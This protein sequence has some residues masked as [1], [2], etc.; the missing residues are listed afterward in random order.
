MT[1]ELRSDWKYLAPPYLDPYT[2]MDAESQSRN[3]PEINV[4]PSAGAVGLRSIDPVRHYEPS[5]HR[6]TTPKPETIGRL[7][8]PRY[9]CFVDSETQLGYTVRKV[10]RTLEKSG[11]IGYIFVSYTRRQFYSQISH[12]PSISEFEKARF[13]AIA[14]RDKTHLIRFAIAAAKEAGVQAFWI[15]FECIQP[16]EEDTESTNAED[17]YRIC[18]IARASHSMIIVLG[19]PLDEHKQHVTNTTR[20]EWLLDWGQRLWTVPEALLCPSEHRIPIYSVG[21]EEPEKVA[22]RNLPALVWDDAGELRQLMDHYEGSLHLTQLELISIALECLHKRQ[23]VKRNA[24]DVVYALMGLLRLRPTVRLTHTEFQAFARLS[25]ANDSDMILER[26]LCLSKEDHSSPWYDMADRW[27]AKLWQIKPLFQISSLEAHD[28][29]TIGNTTGARIDWTSLHPIDFTAKKSNRMTW[30]VARVV[31][32]FWLGMIWLYCGVKFIME[33][34]MFE[35]A[36]PGQ[37]EMH[38]DMDRMAHAF[39]IVWLALTSITLCVPA[40]VTQHFCGE[41]D[42]VQARFFGIEDR[43]R[44]SQVESHL[45][46]A[47][48]GRLKWSTDCVETGV[49]SFIYGDHARLFT[50]ID[51]RSQT[52]TTFK[53]HRPPS[54]VFVGASEQGVLRVLLCS[55]DLGNKSFV[56][57]SVVRLESSASESMHALNRFRFSVSPSVQSAYQDDEQLSFF[58]DRSEIPDIPEFRSLDN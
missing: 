15:D 53:A 23:S 55:Y 22:K 25:L 40:I 58:D 52:A 6:A 27:N 2:D 50:L 32:G 17:V 5:L 29:V 57:E 42:A 16:D 41:L 7:L 11:H 13:S 34:I 14:E 24:G 1:A 21:S 47:N 45:F 31:T 3:A 20:A 8:T 54:L 19:P 12:D 49:D 37:D 33:P 38:E 28:S 30:S 51:T 46:G 43:P 44:L 35:L 36:G 48:C 39:Y 18:D 10:D 9:L 56:K 4:E 26:I